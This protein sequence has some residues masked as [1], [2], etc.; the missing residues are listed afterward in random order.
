MDYKS[1]CSTMDVSHR[2]HFSSFDFLPLFKPLPS[3]AFPPSLMPGLNL[4]IAEISSKLRLK[5]VRNWEASV[6]Q[7]PIRQDLHPPAPSRIFPLLKLFSWYL[8]NILPASTPSKCVDLQLFNNIIINITVKWLSVSQITPN[9][10][11]NIWILTKI[12][13]YQISNI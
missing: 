13:K 4:Q 10:S 3:L 1:K 7:Q 9:K 5:G 2:F 12:F 11:I 8:N 6:G